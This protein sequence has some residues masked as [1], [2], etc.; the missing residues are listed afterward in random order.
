MT[1]AT[2]KLSLLVAGRDEDELEDWELTCIMSVLTSSEASSGEMLR[3]CSLSWLSIDGEVV[4]GMTGGCGAL[5]W[6]VSNDG[7]SSGGEM[8]RVT[9]SGGISS[10]VDGGGLF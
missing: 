4:S 7:M 5:T 1:G 3:K 9:A 10:V 6:A 2:A 8:F